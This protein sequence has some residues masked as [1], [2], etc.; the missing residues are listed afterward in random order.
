[1]INDIWNAKELETQ[2]ENLT[3]TFLNRPTQALRAIKQLVNESFDNQLKKQ[4]N[5]ESKYFNEMTNTK[6]FRHGLEAFLNKALPQF[7]DG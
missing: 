3:N 7:I 5:I 4:M 2:L 6:D 1:M